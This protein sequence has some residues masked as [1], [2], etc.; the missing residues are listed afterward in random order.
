MLKDAPYSD[1]KALLVTFSG[2][3][4]HPSGGDFVPLSFMGGATS[5]TCDLK[6]LA[7]AQDIL[8]TGSLPAGHYTQVRV[9]V[10]SATLYFDN[11]SLSP[12][13]CAANIAAPAGRSAPISVPSGDLRLNREFDLSTSGTTAILLDFDGNQSVKDMGNGSYMMTP[14][15]TV[16][17]VQ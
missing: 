15:I 14:V 6:R 8:G 4:V 3:S 9:V 5:Q 13:P 11:N 17:S 1:A 16:A 12:T 2:V 7:T 10:S